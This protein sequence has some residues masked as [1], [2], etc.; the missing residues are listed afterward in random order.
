MQALRNDVQFDKCTA[1]KTKI[2]TEKLVEDTL[3]RKQ[4]NTE[5]LDEHNLV[6]K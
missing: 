3:V 4:I 2:H 1:L 5:R 6:R